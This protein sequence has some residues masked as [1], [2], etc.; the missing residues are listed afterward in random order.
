M[1][2]SS[3][4]VVDLTQPLGGSTVLWPG[5]RTFSAEVVSELESQGSYAR[6]ITTPEHAGT[7]LDAPAH[8]AAGGWRAHEIPAD[9]LIVPCAVFDVSEVCAADPDHSVQAGD[10]EELERRDGRLEPGWAALLHTGWGRFAGDASRYLGGAARGELHFPGLAPSAA[11]LLL[12]RGVVGIGVD[13]LGVDPGRATE[14]PVHH[15]TL[16]AGLWQLE[17]L[18]NLG[19]LPARGALL[20]VGALPLSEGSG[21]PARVLGLVER[22]AQLGPQEIS[23]EAE[24]G[25]EVP[26]GDGGRR[27]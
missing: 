11:R 17:G 1:A 4:R 15:L 3:F 12:D 25:S 18:V 24:R 21:A 23:I 6:V 14:F 5:S 26:G 10:I 20:F 7:H 27:W 16:P 8:F 9:R 2:P 22:S 13:T 19:A